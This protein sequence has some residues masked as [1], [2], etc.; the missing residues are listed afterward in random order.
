MQTPKTNL[1]RMFVERDQHGTNTFISGR[2]KKVA[3]KHSKKN[4]CE[5]CGW[6]NLLCHGS[7]LVLN[8]ASKS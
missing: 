3:K 8:I 4:Y 2:I 5:N 6:E 1:L 7:G